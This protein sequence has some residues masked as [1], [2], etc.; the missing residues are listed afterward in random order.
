MTDYNYGAANPWWQGSQVGV[1]LTVNAGG[2]AGILPAALQFGWPITIAAGVRRTGSP[3][4]NNSR[5][6]GLTYNNTFT[7]PFDVIGLYFPTSTSVLTYVVNSAGTQQGAN[8]SYTPPLNTDVVLALTVT[9]AGNAILY[10][11]GSQVYSAGS[12]WSNPTYTAT[13]SAYI[14]DCPA[15]AGTRNPQTLMYW[16]AW[17]NRALDPAVHVGIGSN[18]NAIWDVFVPVRGLMTT[19]LVQAALLAYLRAHRSDNRRYWE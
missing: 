6:F 13:A 19:A 4:T 17:W 10:A 15:A 16:F 2:F 18:V 11:G 5:V 7:V 14:G 3:G 8:T 1:N 9:S 12:A